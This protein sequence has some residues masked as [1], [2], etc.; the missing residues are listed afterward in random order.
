M[1]ALNPISRIHRTPDKSFSLLLPSV[2][3]NKSFRNPTL[4]TIASI[5]NDLHQPHRPQK[6]AISIGLQIFSSN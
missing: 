1:I 5:V 3:P 6:L 2:F 4:L